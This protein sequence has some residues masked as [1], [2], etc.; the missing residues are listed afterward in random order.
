M[1]TR[2]VS[3]NQSEHAATDH[4]PRLRRMERLASLLDD[5]LTIPGT[6]IRFGLD[7]VIGLVPGIGDIVSTLI[8]LHLVAEAARMGVPSPV[9]GRMLANIVV[10]MLVGSIPILG[11]VLDVRLRANR[12]NVDLLREHLGS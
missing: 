6:G 8:S 9:L 12:R 7:A 11:D 4:L 3:N 10:D 2:R 5:R 1:M